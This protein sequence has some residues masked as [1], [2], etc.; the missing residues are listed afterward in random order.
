[1]AGYGGMSSLEA[2]TLISTCD[3]NTSFHST[4]SFVSRQAASELGIIKS[5]FARYGKIATVM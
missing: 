4:F 1:L 2:Y 5:C 3:T